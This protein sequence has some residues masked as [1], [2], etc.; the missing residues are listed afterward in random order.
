MAP[1]RIR[2]R[3]GFR[4]VDSAW[5][6][7]QK[8]LNR[9]N[10]S[11]RLTKRQSSR[12]KQVAEA[13]K[14]KTTGLPKAAVKHHHFLRNV[15]VISP[16][17]HKL[18]TAAFSQAQIESTRVT[19]LDELTARIGKQDDA[20]AIHELFQSLFPESQVD[21]PVPRVEFMSAEREGTRQV[22]GEYLVDKIKTAAMNDQW[23]AVSVLLPFYPPDLLETSVMSLE[24]R[25]EC[26]KEL[27]MALYMTEVDWVTDSYR[28]VHVNKTVQIIPHGF[29]WIAVPDEN[30]SAVFGSYIHGVI[31]ACRSRE[32]AKGENGTDCVKMIFRNGQGT[33]NLKMSLIDIPRIQRILSATTA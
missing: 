21:E 7:F 6:Q 1:K 18:C 20:E 24:I 25:E 14:E 3:P 4:D 23:R 9:L 2:S 16:D 28:V 32:L 30:I 5:G 33:I 17:H 27:A 26:V 31:D 19:V 12:F 8:T 10:L 11:R 15:F 29:E 13:V 22:F